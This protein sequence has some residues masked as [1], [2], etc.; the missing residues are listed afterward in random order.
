MSAIAR[1]ASPRISENLIPEAFL[2]HPS[3]A[4]PYGP[5]PGGRA[6][7]PA[8]DDLHAVSS[9]GIASIFIHDTRLFSR[10]LDCPVP[11]ILL[12]GCPQVNRLS[13]LPS[14]RVPIIRVR[15]RMASAHETA[16]SFREG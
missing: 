2:S 11:R 9:Y 8:Q 12:G 1:R 14:R 10:V 3:F 6:P 13:M 16:P 15:P 4:L 7:P 5:L